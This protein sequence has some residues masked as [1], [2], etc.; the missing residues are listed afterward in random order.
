M[1]NLTY[2]DKSIWWHIKQDVKW[3]IFG[4]M[5]LFGLIHSIFKI[6][7]FTALVISVIPIV[8]I[9]MIYESKDEKKK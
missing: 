4:C 2:K 6:D 3:V 9:R 7:E 5:P 8:I 1:I